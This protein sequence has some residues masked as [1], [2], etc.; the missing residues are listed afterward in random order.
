MD[1]VIDSQTLIIKG[2]NN[3]LRREFVEGVLHVSES[4]QWVKFVKQIFLNIPDEGAQ[5][6][7]SK[8]TPNLCML[9]TNRKCEIV[10]EPSLE[11]QNHFHC[12]ENV[13]G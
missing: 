5:Y 4:Y 3:S 9:S 12:C 13:C 10:V 7:L 1:F 6:R 11:I 8:P 2:H